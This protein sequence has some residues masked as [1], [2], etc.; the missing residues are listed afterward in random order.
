[1][2]AFLL[3]LIVDLSLAVIAPVWGQV[4]DLA[5]LATRNGTINSIQGDLVL[6]K[7]DGPRSDYFLKVFLDKSTSGLGRV[8]Q[9]GQRIQVSGIEEVDA[10]YPVLVVSSFDQIH[11]IDDKDRP[12]KWPNPI[13]IDGDASIGR[14]PVLIFTAP[15]RESEAKRIHDEVV[16]RYQLDQMA[17]Y[18]PTAAILGSLIGHLLDPI[19]ILLGCSIAWGI[20]KIQGMPA[21]FR[22]RLGFVFLA[23]GGELTI[24]YIYTA[25]S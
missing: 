25:L 3:S 5:S 15:I 21:F 18:H 12:I 17:Q 23:I 6:L 2:R 10:H 13:R 8:L 24:S 4:S 11:Q 9:S 7:V 22:S 14:L 20:R 19:C 16:K 1:M